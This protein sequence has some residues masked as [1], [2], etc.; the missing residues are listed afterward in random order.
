M[1][2]RLRSFIESVLFAGMKPAAQADP[3]GVSNRTVGQKIK[4][5]LWI[6]IPCVI[7]AG[8]LVLLLPG[9]SSKAPVNSLPDAGR[10]AE[11][12]R[13]VE[14]VEV[15]INKTG[16]MALEGT[17]RNTTDRPIRAVEIVFNLSDAGGSQLGGV[18][19][20][21]ENLPSR[22]TKNFRVP[23][24][25]RNAERALVREIRTE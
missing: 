24:A 25:Q 12:T 18:S 3:L 16:A 5:G 6:G 1:A 15:H 17:V 21:V 10:T 13:D 22:S 9:R 7:V 19:A 8:V 11:I 23:I 14:V 2:S 4:L 20:R